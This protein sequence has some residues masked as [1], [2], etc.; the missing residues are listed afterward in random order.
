MLGKEPLVVIGSLSRLMVEK[1][2]EPIL[3]VRGWINVQIAIAVTRL[4]SRM[5]RGACPPSPLWDQDP[6]WDLVLGLGLA[7]ETAHQNNLVRTP[8]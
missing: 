2:D 5:I 8:L 3:H 7:Q 1:I 4:Y 6:D